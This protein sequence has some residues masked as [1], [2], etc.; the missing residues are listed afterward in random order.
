[1]RGA[2]VSNS[3]ADG[4]LASNKL[5]G[6]VGLQSGVT[7]AL[8]GLFLFFAWCRGVGPPVFWW[9]QEVEGTSLR[10]VRGSGYAALV[11]TASW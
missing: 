7:A 11:G 8:V 3:S 2:S 1:M 6:S 5:Q 4:R 10:C 9:G